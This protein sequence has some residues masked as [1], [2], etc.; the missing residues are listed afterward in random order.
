RTY[1]LRGYIIIKNS[2]KGD[3][4][5][6]PNIIEAIP[7]SVCG[8]CGACGFC[9]GGIIPTSALLVSLDSLLG[10]IEPIGV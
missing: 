8:A 9:P 5:F 10:M 6:S 1:I 3:K 2:L 4:M 7:C